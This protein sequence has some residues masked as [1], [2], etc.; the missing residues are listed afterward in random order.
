[1][2][3]VD[4]N[5]VKDYKQVHST[6]NKFNSKH[7]NENKGDNTRS[8]N[9]IL[10]MLIGA[11]IIV[12]I[13]AF[14]ILYI[15]RYVKMNKLNIKINQAQE[16]IEELQTQKQKLKLKVSQYKSLGRIEKIAKKDLEMKE[17]NRVKYLSMTTDKSE[18]STTKQE[19]ESTTKNNLKQINRLGRSVVV[20]LKSFTKVEAGTLED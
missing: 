2:I 15:N 11:L 14:L 9:I 16:N 18:H 3:V 8:N 10:W 5:K 13:G 20:W 17:P 6:A 12:I 7:Q 4:N 1:M 19:T